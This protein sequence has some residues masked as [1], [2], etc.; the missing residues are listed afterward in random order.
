MRDGHRVC[1]G[2]LQWYIPKMLS[3]KPGRHTKLVTATIKKLGPSIPLSHA[4]TGMYLV[5]QIKSVKETAIPPKNNTF[6]ASVAQ[7]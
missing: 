5:N 6:H 2:I 7:Q 1:L 3:K 4:P